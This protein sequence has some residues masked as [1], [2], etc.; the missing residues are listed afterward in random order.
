MQRALVPCVDAIGLLHVVCVSVSLSVKKEDK[1]NFEYFPLNFCIGVC[2]S[3][4]T[5]EQCA[6]GC[7]AVVLMMC[8]MSAEVMCF[9]ESSDVLFVQVKVEERW[10]TLKKKMATADYAGKTPAKI[11]DVDMENLGKAQKEQQSLEQQLH[12]M[13][14]LLH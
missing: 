2:I 5:E 1:S 14:Q 10:N 9:V 6:L 12:D 13:K 8:G 7:R 4:S 3:D 11:K